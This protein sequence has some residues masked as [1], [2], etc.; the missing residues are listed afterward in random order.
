MSFPASGIKSAWRN[1]YVEVV[2]YLDMHHPK[3]YWFFNCSEKTYDKARFE[4]RVSNYNW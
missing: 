3:K 4:N 2:R 1:N